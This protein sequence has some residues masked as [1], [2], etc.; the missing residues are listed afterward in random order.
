[1]EAESKYTCRMDY[2]DPDM[3]N[4][5]TSDIRARR[6]LEFL[7]S[8]LMEKYLPE[9]KQGNLSVQEFSYRNY[10]IFIGGEPV[11][12]TLCYASHTWN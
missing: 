6:T 10:K 7:P 11:R 8:S 4:S 2:L 1:M 9:N 5:V 12:R 3:V